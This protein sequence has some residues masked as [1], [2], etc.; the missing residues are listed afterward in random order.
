MG[1]GARGHTLLSHLPAAHG[2]D[3]DRF[4]NAPFGFS[5]FLTSHLPAPLLL[6]LGF[7]SPDNDSNQVLFQS[8]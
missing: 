2:C 1:Q 6:F 4:H 7:T 5:V 3:P 8:L